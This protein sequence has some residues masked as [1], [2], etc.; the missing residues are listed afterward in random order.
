MQREDLYGLKLTDDAKK[1]LVND[2]SAFFE[3]EIGE[4]L[5]IF[6]AEAVVDF[7]VKALGP[8]AYNLALDHVKG[9]YQQK[10]EDMSFEYD[11]L[12]RNTK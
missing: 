8:E 6:E 3:D 7:F 11:M 5:G 2:F 9:W 10:Q 12:Y 4:R 1:A